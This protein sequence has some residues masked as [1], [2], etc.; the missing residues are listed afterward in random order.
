MTEAEAQEQ[1]L[2]WHLA[3]MVPWLRLK[4]AQNVKAFRLARGD[5]KARAP[6]RSG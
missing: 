5:C 4:H 6:A 3:V 1:E 2:R